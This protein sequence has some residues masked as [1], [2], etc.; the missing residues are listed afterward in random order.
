MDLR[1]DPTGP[2]QGR[3]RPHRAERAR[4]SHCH[5]MDM[6]H[7]AA[8]LPDHRY[9]KSAS[10]DM[11]WQALL[12]YDWVPVPLV[13][14]QVIFLAVRFYFVICL[15]GRQFIVTGKNPSG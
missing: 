4:S 11:A 10:S 2:G 12:K 1:Q 13:Y 6:C 3:R 15:F 7:G 9:R 5:G 14:P 8:G